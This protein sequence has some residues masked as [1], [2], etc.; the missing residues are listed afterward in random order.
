MKQEEIKHL[1][2][3]VFQRTVRPGNPLAGLLAVMEDLHEPSEDVLG[4]LAT[5]FNPYQAPD[6]FVP[7][8]AGWVDLDMFLREVPEGTPSGAQSTFPTGTG[9]LRELVAAAAYLSRWR[10]TARGLLLFLETAT[11]VEGFA[12]DEQV[13]DKSGRAIPYH[14]RVHAPAVVKQHET[15]IRRIV[16]LEK[17]AYVTFEVQFDE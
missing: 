5:F 9:R 1:L 6:A 17:P 10:G 15:L 16:Q 13:L 2:P 12:V 14:I 8:L 4:R 3:E 7:Y 11:G